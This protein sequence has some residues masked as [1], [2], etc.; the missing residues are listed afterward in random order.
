MSVPL[1]NLYD[2]F[3]GIS[4]TN[5][6]IYRWN[7]HGS[8]KLQDLVQHRPPTW[9]T[10]EFLQGWIRPN[11]IFHDQEPLDWD[12]YSPTAVQDF[13]SLYRPNIAFSKSLREIWTNTNVRAALPP[14]R[15]SEILLA[16]SDQGGR[17]LELYAN[18]GFIPVFVW[19]HALIARDWYRFAEHDTRLYNQDQP[20]WFN[21]HARAWQGSREYR[22]A[23]VDRVLES[24]L[25][26]VSR[27][28][29][30]Q[31]DQGQHVRDHRF[32]DARWCAD[33]DRLC[34]LSG[35]SS[36]NSS[37]S[38]VYD[39][40][41]FQQTR[42]DI[43]LET[44]FE[45]DRTHLTEKILR[46]LACR[47]PFVL[48]AGPEGLAW[49]HRYGFRSFGEI[50]DESYDQILDPQKRMSAIVDTM[51][52]ITRLDWAQCQEQIQEICQH[53]HHRFFS[54]AFQDQVC[55]E[56]RNNLATA[57]DQLGT[58]TGTLWNHMLQIG[59]DDATVYQWFN[60]PVLDQGF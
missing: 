58:S 3:E 20:I 7:D 56:Y 5:V 24:G 21:I 44:R 59:L 15:C 26:P 2:F 1:D 51:G 28:G 32:A 35:Q 60:R 30:Q 14:N 43:V 46:C 33:L 23:F 17:D 40:N 39:I 42:I 53:N 36:V 37:A 54:K 22:L 45:E 52:A 13:I 6:V 49:L 41:E 19:S 31:H 16:H 4:D 25:E 18:N 10:N 38:A 34:Q 48:A 11:I 47:R 8:K 27:I 29:F 57:I 9:D 55:D 12:L 50:W